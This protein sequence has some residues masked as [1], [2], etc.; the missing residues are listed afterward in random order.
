MNWIVIDYISYLRT[1][2]QIAQVGRAFS[3]AY[4]GIQASITLH[5]KFLAAIL[6]APIVFFDIT[7]VRI[8]TS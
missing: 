6:R 1:H 8:V 4:G 2:I 7:P 3:Q 5:Q